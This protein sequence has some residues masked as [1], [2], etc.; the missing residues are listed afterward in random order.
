MHDRQRLPPFPAAA[1]LA[2][3]LLALGATAQELRESDHKVWSLLLAGRP[4]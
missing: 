3:S 1:G 4:V 2:L